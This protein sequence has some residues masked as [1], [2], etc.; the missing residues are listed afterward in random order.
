MCRSELSKDKQTPWL[1]ST[2]KTPWDS[3]FI[4]WTQ[5][6]VYPI[7]TK[8][9]ER[10]F[11][12]CEIPVRCILN[13]R[14]SILRIDKSNIIVHNEMSDNL[15][16]PSSNSHGHW[17]G[18]WLC[19]PSSWRWAGISK[20]CESKTNY[21]VARLTGHPSNQDNLNN[22]ITLLQALLFLFQYKSTSINGAS[23]Y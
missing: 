17:S 23:L 22:Q 5:F 16:E 13:F 9:V 14:Q 20:T 10:F 1:Q 19:R 8:H 6:C 12:M 21:T 3:A 18:A 7:K 4:M 11:F 15:L 2:I